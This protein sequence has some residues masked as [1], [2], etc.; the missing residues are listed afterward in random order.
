MAI[1]N[2]WSSGQRVE[3]TDFNDITNAIW[4]TDV[5]RRAAGIFIVTKDFGALGN[6][7]GD[8]QPAF[9]AAIEAAVANDGG[10]VLV[11]PGDYAL[12]API[13]P[14][15]MGTASD[16]A[17]NVQLMGVGY[18]G[19]N[20]L[21]AGGARLQSKGD[22]EVIGGWWNACQITGF[23]MD[24]EGHNAPAIKADLSKS[25]ISHNE[26]IGWVGYGMQLCTDSWKANGQPTYLNKIEYNHVQQ[27]G[28][29]GIYA[30][31]LMWDSYIRFNNIGSTEANIM[32]EGGPH[33]IHYNWLDGETGPKHN[34]HM[35]NV[36]H[37]TEIV[38]N[39]MEN[40]KRESVLIERPSWETGDRRL[41]FK[42]VGNQILN[43]G[44][45]GSVGTYSAVKV[46]GNA[47]S[48]TGKLSGLMFNNNQFFDDEGG[49]WKHA[50]EL[51]NINHGTV[52]GNDWSNNG[53]TATEAL[54]I[55]NC[56]DVQ[57]VGN[58]GGSTIK[59]T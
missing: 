35:A 18:R 5:K 41:S 33:K 37:T 36:G 1:R 39:Y 16:A 30:S 24:V 54:R 23:C 10:T 50:I 6:G 55:V 47:G 14:V 49:H 40:C 53:Y 57:V 42:I 38:G 56:S 26:L 20:G 13:A 34:I 21:E 32:T 22:Y 12:G 4:D 46:V 27:Q 43:G 2:D 51:V 9:M 25:I 3:A 7:T 48:D 45:E 17:E 8:D 19:L 44:H 28:G 31:Y 29:I 11:P 59:T 15:D 52:V 58:A